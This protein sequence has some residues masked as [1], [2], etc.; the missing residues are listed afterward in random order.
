MLIVAEM[1]Y[2]LKTLRNLILDPKEQAPNVFIPSTD[3][4]EDDRRNASDPDEDKA[5]GGNLDQS[6]A[7]I[8][9]DDIAETGGTELPDA[10]PESVDVSMHQCSFRKPAPRKFE[11]YIT[12]L[13]V[14]NLE[15]GTFEQALKSTDIDK[16]K[17]AMEINSLKKNNVWKLVNL[18]KNRRAIDIKWVYNMGKE[19]YRQAP[20]TNSKHV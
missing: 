6:N 10:L 13:T 1:L 12:Y 3:P 14:C 7:D 15:P 19:T 20:P 9:A 18:P 11:D 5:E 8:V 4:D 2:F 16:W 17:L